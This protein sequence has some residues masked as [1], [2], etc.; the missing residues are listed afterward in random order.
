MSKKNL[1]EYKTPGIPDDLFD[2]SEKVPITKEEIRSVIISKLRLK[3]GYSTIDIGCGSGSITIELAL[4]TRSTVYAVDFDKN[5]LQL[6]K[7]NATKFGL[8]DK[9]EIIEGLAQDIL[10]KLPNVNAIII[11]GTTAGETEQVIKQAIDK[12]HK[13]GRLVVTAILIET[14]Y[15]TLKTMEESNL[16]EIDITQIAVSKSRNTSSGTMMLSRNPIIIFSATR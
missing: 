13:G 14:I 12:L 9:L 15:K 1:W 10:P 7:D 2:R 6:T 4:Q 5:A 3:E 8:E 11:G 16:K